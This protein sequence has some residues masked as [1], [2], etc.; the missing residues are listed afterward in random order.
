MPNEP[1]Q[2]LGLPGRIIEAR[3]F[4][5]SNPDTQAGAYAATE[6]SNNSSIYQATVTHDLVGWHH[7][8][9]WDTGA[10]QSLGVW[11]VNLTDTTVLNRAEARKHSIVDNPGDYQADVSTL[12]SRLTSDRA[13]YLDKL[14]VSGTLAH[15][16]AADTYKASVAGL[17]EQVH[18]DERLSSTRAGHID[19]LNVSGT[20]AHTDN[21]ETFRANLS[22]VALEATSQS[23]KGVTDRV[24][25][26]IE[27]DDGDRFTAKAL[28]EGPVADT[29]GLSAFDPATDKVIVETNEDKTGYELSTTG[30]AAIW[31]RLT[32]AL[33][34]AGSIGKLLVDMLNVPVGSR[35]APEDKMDIVDAPNE[36]AVGVIQEGLSTFDHTQNT[37][38]TDSESR[39]ASKADLSG[40]VEKTD[41][42]E[43]FGEMQINASGHVSRV[44]LVDTTTTNTDMRGTENALP[45]ASYTAPDNAGIDAAKTAAEAVKVQTDK[46]D[47][48][49]E[50]GALLSESTNMRGTD[51]ALTD[52]TGYTLDS[53]EHTAIANVLWNL[54]NAIEQGVSPIQALRTTF[55]ADVGRLSGAGTETVVIRDFNNTK[56]AITATVDVPG[57]RLTITVDLD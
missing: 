39:E 43:N 54:A 10:N 49:G 19:K 22:D 41:L 45:A 30:V 23:I 48:G 7:L 26:L 1:I 55:R 57:N 38:T 47:F 28:E 34:T 12:E 32:S 52:K 27:D 17:L 21:A 44:T 18:F 11:D 24:N 13:G 6:L 25:G 42:P 56:D 33:T 20:V 9:V 5:Y 3:L 46:L 51:G 4:P 16:D 14:D 8:N 15:S 36:T 29:E 31:N 2:F 40:I 53:D 50:D 35:A 37:V